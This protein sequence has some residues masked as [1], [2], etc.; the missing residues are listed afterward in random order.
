[1]HQTPPTHLTHRQSSKNLLR[2][3]REQLAARSSIA[4]LPTHEVDV[5]DLTEEIFAKNLKEN[6]TSI[7]AKT[8]LLVPVMH[9]F[10]EFKLLLEEMH[11]DLA[12]IRGKR[13]TV[14]S[15]GY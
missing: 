15:S 3:Q 13:C 11:S 2:T 10:A 14:G 6:H 8:P 9:Q 7:V 12:G 1:M 5:L 4:G